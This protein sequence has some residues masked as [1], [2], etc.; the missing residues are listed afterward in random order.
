MSLAVFWFVPGR[1]FF[2]A[3][4]SVFRL[5]LLALLSFG[6]FL[7]LHSCPVAVLGKG[8]AADLAVLVSDLQN[9]PIV[10]SF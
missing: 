7:V 10:F 9:F 4:G 2:K 8:W 5:G 1:P 6:V 3:P